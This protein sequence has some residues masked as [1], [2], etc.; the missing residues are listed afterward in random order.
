M[1]EAAKQNWEDAIDQFQQAVDVSEQYG[2]ALH[3]AEARLQWAAAHL[4]RRWRGDEEKAGE[5]LEQSLATFRSCGA[6]RHAEKAAAA[7]KPIARVAAR[8]TVELM[9][10]ISGEESERA[11]GQ[12]SVDGDVT[13]LFTDIESSTEMWERL[14]DEKAQEVLRA[15]NRITR[16]EI[17]E[18]GGTEVKAQ[19]DGFMVAFSNVR[20]P[21]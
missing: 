15:H 5:L 14:G 12:A 10:P 11:Q 8:D 1:Y 17:E 13:I 19:G 2:L 9:L 7:L 18:Q 6:R 4:A 21:K 3:S 16:L 20:R